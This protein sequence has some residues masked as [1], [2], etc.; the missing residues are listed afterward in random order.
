MTSQS[1]KTAVLLIN[2]GSPDEPT[3]ASL[4]RYL[5]EF[6]SD[7]R[8]V[9]LNPIFWK[10]LLNLVII[11]RRSPRSAERYRKVWTKD[12]APLKIYT[13]RIARLL[14]ERLDESGCN[15]KVAVGMR[16][17]QPSQITVFKDL[18]EKEGFDRIIV[19]PLY[20]QYASSTTASVSDALA[21]ALSR[22]RSH[23][24]VRFIRDYHTHPLYIRALANSI[25]AH[26]SQHGEL[27]EKGKLILSFHG[28]P[29]RYCDDG[30]PYPKQV[31]ETAGLLI[32]QL[33]IEPEQVLLSYQSRFG[34]EEWL[35][36]YTTDVI[37]DLARRGVERIDVVCPGF[38]TDCLETLEE[39]GIDLK[40]DWINAGGKE[41]HYIPCI[42]DSED[43]LA[44]VEDL[45][46]A[47]ISTE[48]E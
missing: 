33:G 34:K 14:Q 47:E 30:D 10:T 11:P 19:L 9:D 36:P 48:T 35:K 40:N 1:K 42:N 29:I 39:I 7:R 43:S 24:E 21:T 26:W 15:A 12:G 4:K 28:M 17:G 37:K 22:M 27:G 31:K 46:R 23:P 18:H 13:D 2:L 25:K 20:P 44:L 6:L 5:K 38:H 3:A 45:V 32:Q 41:F 16:Y 8:V